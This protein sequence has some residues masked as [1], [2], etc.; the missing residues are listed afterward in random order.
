MCY[1]TM[2]LGNVIED[3]RNKILSVLIKIFFVTI[4]KIFNI[5]I[6]TKLTYIFT[7]INI[8][9]FLLNDIYKKTLFLLFYY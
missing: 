9:I 8:S 7:T 2:N 1:I 6:D 5:V 4:I 3:I